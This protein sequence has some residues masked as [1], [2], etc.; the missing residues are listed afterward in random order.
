[1]RYKGKRPT[2]GRGSLDLGIHGI[3][4]G[5]NG[6]ALQIE[7]IRAREMVDDRKYVG[8]GHYWES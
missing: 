1:V 4:R 7:V 6:E 5:Y 8:D 2:K 3:A